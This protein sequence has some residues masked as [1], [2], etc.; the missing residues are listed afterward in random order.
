M[1]TFSLSL[2]RPQKVQDVLP[3]ALLQIVYDMAFPLSGVL[4]RH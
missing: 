2:C 4:L 3:K 1:A